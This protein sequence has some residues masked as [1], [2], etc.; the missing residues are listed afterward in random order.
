MKTGTGRIS[1][2]LGEHKKS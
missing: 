2:H 1:L